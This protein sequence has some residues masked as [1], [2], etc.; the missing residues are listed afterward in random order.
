MGLSY[1]RH[2]HL[3]NQ[4]SEMN[5]LQFIATL[6]CIPK[7]VKEFFKEEDDGWFKGEIKPFHDGPLPETHEKTIPFEEL[8]TGDDVFKPGCFTIRGEDLVAI[9]DRDNRKRTI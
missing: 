1:H 3:A 9:L 8:N 7:G 6:F 5:R 4:K 2:H